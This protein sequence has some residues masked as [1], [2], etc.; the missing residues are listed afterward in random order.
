M[1]YTKEIKTNKVGRR[2]FIGL[3]A[4]AFAGTALSSCE[5]FLD[6]YIPNIPP[7]IPSASA[8]RNIIIIGSGFGGAVTAKRLTEAGKEVTLFERGKAWKP[9]GQTRIYSKTIPVDKR[10]TWLSD[11]ASFFYGPPLTSE[12]YI[13]VLETNREQNI[14]VYAGAG[15]GGG[16]L[17]WGGIFTRPDKV[18]FDMVF[19]SEISYDELSSTYFPRAEGVLGSSL[20]PDDIKSRAPYQYVGVNERQSA[21]AGFETKNV[22]LAYDWNRIREEFDG[23][24][25][26]SAIIG[27]S[28]YGVSSGSKI[29]LDENY[30]RDAEATGNLEVKLQHI[31]KEVGKN[32]DGKYWVYVEEIT[33]RGN[34]VNRMT[35]TCNYLFMAAG[36]MGTS[37]LLVK[38]KAKNT[39]PNLNEETGK[40]WGNNGNAIVLRELVGENVGSI[41]GSP[42]P[43]GTTDY[44]NPITPIFIE[45]TQFPLG[46]ECQCLNNFSLGVSPSRGSFVF[47]QFNDEARLIWPYNGND[48]INQAL[49]HYSRRINEVTGSGFSPFYG[50]VPFDNNCY[51]ACG[52]MV[53]GKA[54][55]FYGRVQNH[56]KLYVMDGSMLPGSAACANPS[57]TITALAE[58]N[59]ERILE[60]DF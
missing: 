57:L 44:D 32:E 7:T 53:L 20:M 1:K 40:G 19:P 39:L 4:L 36:S 55:D 48:L 27:E 11:R 5:D 29:Q 28:V 42:S 14:D 56:E 59:V 25:I 15:Y 30:L 26:K 3:S 50:E 21:E 18:I 38:A 23:T 60:E 37:K 6:P 31:I 45:H 8:H 22:G 16:S 51:H 13:G 35:Y 49:M 52:G 10:G 54:T 34:V 58:R 41:Q 17:V 24:R 47:D 33:P 2:R 46:I 12:K 43:I 9:N